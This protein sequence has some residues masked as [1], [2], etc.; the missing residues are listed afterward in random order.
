MTDQPLPF[1][2]ATPARRWTVVLHD[3]ETHTIEALAFRVEGGAL[4]MVKPAGLV[5]AYAQGVWRTCEPE[6]TP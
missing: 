6:G 3:G 4:L 2:P 1:T 5:S